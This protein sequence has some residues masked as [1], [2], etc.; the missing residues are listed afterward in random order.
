[1]LIVF[2]NTSCGSRIDNLK[3]LLMDNKCWILENEKR[4]LKMGSDTLRKDDHGNLGKWCFLK[5]NEFLE[6]TSTGS[7]IE[8]PNDL[9]VE[10]KWIIEDEGKLN[11]YGE[12]Y[13]VD[14]FS[15]STIVL[16]RKFDK[17]IYKLRKAEVDD[18]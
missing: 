15:E 17:A 1:M 12:Q 7:L 10:R 14:E 6:Y 5:N 13:E 2:L 11:I 3:N 9:E 4:E 16:I 18:E 8:F